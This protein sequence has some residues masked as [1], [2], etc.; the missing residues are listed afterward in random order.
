MGNILCCSKKPSPK[1]DSS[2]DEKGEA[3]IVNL[4]RSIKRYDIEKDNN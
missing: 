2:D 4:E 3:L 1:D